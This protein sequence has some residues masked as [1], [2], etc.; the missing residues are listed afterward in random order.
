MVV[1]SHG[2]GEPQRRD[3]PCAAQAPTPVSVP[4]L[5]L[6][7]GGQ[8]GVTGWAWGH[9]GTSMGNGVGVPGHVPAMRTTAMAERGSQTQ[10]SGSS[11]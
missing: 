4:C 7:C 5:S 6:P 8:C 10:Q 11:L 1:W 3:A 2:G 9:G